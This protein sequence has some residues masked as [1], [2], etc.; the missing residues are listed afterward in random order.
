MA[1][2]LY[3]TLPDAAREIPTRR[4]ARCAPC[5]AFSLDTSGRHGR[6][7]PSVVP[8]LPW[9]AASPKRG[10]RFQASR[11]NPLRA[12]LDRIA[13]STQARPAVDSG[14]THDDV[15]RG[16]YIFSTV[17][18][19]PSPPSSTPEAP[20]ALGT[21]MPLSPG[22]ATGG[23]RKEA[24]HE[25]DG[26]GSQGDGPSGGIRCL[27]GDGN[28]HADGRSSAGWFSTKCPRCERTE[29][30]LPSP[31]I[32]FKKASEMLPASPAGRNGPAKSSRPPRRRRR[33]GRLP[34]RVRSGDPDADRACELPSLSRPHT[35]E[36]GLRV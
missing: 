26:A 23:F 13:F 2:R 27:P 11:V 4:E 17:G 16:I 3:S 28:G 19:F 14:T 1:V 34:R 10:G 30:T 5:P 8:R 29:P 18:N 7:L 21:A 12:V 31:A 35:G 15:D 6:C 20:D 9:P 33:A 32:L 22:V 25:D 24:G 36:G